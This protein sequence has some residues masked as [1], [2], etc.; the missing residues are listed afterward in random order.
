HQHNV[1]LVLAAHIVTD[2]A[3]DEGSELTDQEHIVE[4]SDR[5]DERA[6][7]GAC[8]EKLDRQERGQAAEDVEVVPLDHVPDSC[9]DDDTPQVLRGE[10]RSGHN[11]LRGRVEG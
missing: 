8:R 7:G 2:R 4:Y 5:H 11:S 10:L 1:E 9:G 6:S 3:E